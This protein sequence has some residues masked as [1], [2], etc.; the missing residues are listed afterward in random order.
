[1]LFVVV[2]LWVMVGCNLAAVWMLWHA[3]LRQMEIL[4]QLDRN[5][6]DGLLQVAEALGDDADDARRLISWVWDNDEV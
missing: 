5:L 6:R 3:L 2:L 4:A 1:M